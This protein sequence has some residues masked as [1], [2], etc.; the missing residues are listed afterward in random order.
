MALVELAAG[1]SDGS[2]VAIYPEG[3]DPGSGFLLADIVVPGEGCFY[4]AW[5]ALGRDHLEGLIA[6]LR[7]V[8]GLRAPTVTPRTDADTKIIDGGDPPWDA[9]AVAAAD[10][11]AVAFDRSLDGQTVPVM[12]FAD[13]GVALA[14]ATVRPA[15]IG[16]W[17]AAWDHPTGLGHDA[18]NYPC[19]N[20]GRGVIGIGGFGPYEPDGPGPWAR[21]ALAKITWDDGS[22]AVITWRIGDLRLPESQVVFPDPETG[23]LVP[24]GVQAMVYIPNAGTYQVW[25]HLG[26][27]HLLSLLEA[28]RFVQK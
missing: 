21:P 28:M 4:Q 8:E 12:A 19:A 15:A 13:V 1:L 11:V 6:Q 17:G 5:S 26:Y 23:E 27:D 14:S 3:F 25:S 10:L 9:P 24:D 2:L 22:Q 20:C 18:G 7:K 16:N